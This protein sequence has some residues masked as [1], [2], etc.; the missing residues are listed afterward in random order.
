MELVSKAL[1][2]SKRSRI[3]GA[4]KYC[5]I[6]SLFFLFVKN[7]I[8]LQVVISVASVCQLPGEL[9]AVGLSLAAL[10]QPWVLVL[11]RYAVSADVQQ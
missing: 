9:S 7:S 11:R 8:F 1:Q 10:E 6:F 3:D 2:Q 5:I 4:M